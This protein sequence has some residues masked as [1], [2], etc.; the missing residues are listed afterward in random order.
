[1]HLSWLMTHDDVTIMCLAVHTKENIFT[2][3]KY[4]VNYRMLI[5]NTATILV[6]CYIN[7]YVT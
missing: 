7:T 6:Y 5:T 4:L 1:M 2:K 3:L